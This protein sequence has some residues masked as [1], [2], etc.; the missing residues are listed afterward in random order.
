VISHNTL[1]G[2]DPFPLIAES[3]QLVEPIP[4]ISL[5]CVTFTLVQT[6]RYVKALSD[7]QIELGRGHLIICDHTVRAAQIPLEPTTMLRVHV[8]RK[9]LMRELRWLVR[10]PRLQG[11]MSAVGGRKPLLPLVVDV[12][13][14]ILP[15]LTAAMTAITGLLGTQQSPRVFARLARFLD[16]MDGI[17]QSLT[18]S[19]QL[20]DEHPPHPPWRF[21]LVPPARWHPALA[22]AARLLYQDPGASWNLDLLA[23]QAHVS[24]RQLTRLFR[25]QI[26]LSAMQYLTEIRLQRLALTLESSALSFTRAA[27]CIGWRN[28]HHARAL[29]L[30]RYGQDPDVYRQRQRRRELPEQP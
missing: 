5:D 12:A 9:L 1:F 21:P 28:S 27:R 3:V 4:P 14:E 29:F 10:C 24:R 13:P 8:G 11:L 20:D 25:E 7:R 2:N 15:S 26:G 17:E 18:V 16:L 30:R 22:H 23:G 6:G 19:A